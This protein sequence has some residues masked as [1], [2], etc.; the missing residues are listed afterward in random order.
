MGLGALIG[1][2]LGDLIYKYYPS[3]PRDT[4]NH[5]TTIF[6]SCA[7]CI[8]LGTRLYEF[9]K[10]RDDKWLQ[11]S[12]LIIY[13]MGGLILIGSLVLTTFIK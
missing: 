8:F 11:S 5:K 9:S 4:L 6:I 10:D 3:I 13:M 2:G 12:A 7:I 1:I